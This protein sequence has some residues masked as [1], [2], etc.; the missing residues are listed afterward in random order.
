MTQE[1]RR[2]TQ[3]W[4]TEQA[5]SDVFNW[6]KHKQPPQG[7][8]T[9]QQERAFNDRLAKCA[10]NPKGQLTYDGKVVT[11]PSAKQSTLEHLYE[12]EP[13]AKGVGGQRLYQ[14]VRANYIGISRSDCTAFLKKQPVYQLT[15]PANHRTNKPI[16]SDGV[17]ALWC[18]DLMD[19]NPYVRNNRKNYRYIMT[20]IDAYSRHVWLQRLKYKT[21]L[22]CSRA[23]RGIIER[24]GVAPKALLSDN[25]LEFKGE[26]DE[27]LKDLGIAHR[28]TRSYSAQSNGIAERANQEIRNRLRTLFVDGNTLDWTDKLR[29]VERAI[30]ESYHSELRTTPDTLWKAAPFK[31]RSRRQMSPEELDINRR[32]AERVEEFQHSQFKVGDKVRVALSAFYS[33]VRK[34]EK[35]GDS[36]NLVVKWTPDVYEVTRVVY[37]RQKNKLERP[38]YE[39]G[40]AGQLFQTQRGQPKRF[41]ASQL[42]AVDGT[43]AAVPL[44]LDRVLKLNKV[45]PTRNDEPVIEGG[46]LLF[47]SLF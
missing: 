22:E 9:F 10:L 4:K 38:K 36:K 8:N 42:L 33:G 31:K 5:Y 27:A 44:S 39:V 35:A 37:P 28:N 45:Q 41:Y 13:A 11:P 21:A 25:G 46:C 16:V 30:N 3:L 23:F 26:F 15:R 14:F 47:R 7:V 40:H 17:N 1:Y 32:Q 20:V 2:A 24:A 18:I 34:I 43:E 19:M 6:L 12:T 29:T